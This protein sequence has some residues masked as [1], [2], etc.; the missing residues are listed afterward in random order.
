MSIFS[1]EVS[2]LLTELEGKSDQYWNIPKEV[3]QMLYFLVR[4][5]KPKRVLEIGTSNGYSG[6]WLAQALA[7]NESDFGVS[8]ALYT[9]ES[10]QERFSLAADNFAKAGLVKYVKQVFGHAPEVFEMSLDVKAGEFDLLFFDATKKQHLEFLTKGLPLLKVGGVVIADNVLS[11]WD[12]MQHF[13]A[14]A[15][16]LP[17]LAGDLLKIGDGVY[18]AVKRF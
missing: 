10:H 14:Y 18:I 6:I 16:G 1:K 5:A 3:A 8:G 11:H 7:Q 12:E 15:D 13:V 9:V 4:T 17:K 2:D